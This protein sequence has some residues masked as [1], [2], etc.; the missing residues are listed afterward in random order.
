MNVLKKLCSWIDTVNEWVG[1]G[2]AWVTLVLV[3]VVFIDVVLRYVFNISFVFAQELEWHL[4]AFIFLIGAGYTLLHDGHVRVDIF[5]QRLG[6]RGRAWINLIGVIF[7]LLPGCIL[8]ILT[9]LNFVHN[10]WSVME[11]SPDPG[12][13]P[14]RFIV[15][16]TIPVGFFLLCLQGISLGLHSLFQILGIEHVAEEKS[17]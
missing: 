2:V 15:K 7:F 12:G 6:Y 14:F 3:L 10:S 8:V 4:F 16:G 1:R 13:I 9:S 5:Y 11:G 17:A